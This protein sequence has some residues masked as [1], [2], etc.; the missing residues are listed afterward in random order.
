MREPFVP[1]FFPALGAQVGD[2]EIQ[3]LDHKWR[4]ICSK[5]ANWKAKREEKE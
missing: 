2:V 5:M 1:M 4:V 3:Y